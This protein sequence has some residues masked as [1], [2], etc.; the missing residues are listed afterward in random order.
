MSPET[1]T[2]ILGNVGYAGNWSQPASHYSQVSQPSIPVVPGYRSRYWGGQRFSRK[3]SPGCVFK[4]MLTAGDGTL[5]FGLLSM[6]G[7]FL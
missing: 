4:A 3:L 6:D 2:Y 5:E 7:A 1:N